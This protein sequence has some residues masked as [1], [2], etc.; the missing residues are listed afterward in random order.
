MLRPA[1]LVLLLTG[2]TP[3]VFAQP[4]SETVPLLREIK[5]WVVGCDNLRNCHALSA[6]SG[7]DEEDYSSLTLHI[8]HQAGPQGYPRLR[9]DHRGQDVD[10]S[11]LTL[12]GQPLGLELTRELHVE[13]D[14]QG[15]DPEVQ[16]YGVIDDAATR[17]WLQRLRNGQ[18]LQLPGE[19]A[20]HVSLSGLSAS[21]LLMDAVQGR[22][23]NVTALARPGKGAPSEVPP[24]APTPILRKFTPAPPLTAQE[25]AGLVAAALQAVTPE[26]GEPE[27]KAGA[28]TARQAMTVTRYDCAAYNCEFNVSSRER[29]APYTETLMDLQPLPLEDA[30]L[31]GSVGYDEAS[32]TLSYFYKQRGIGD[33]GGGASWVFD[34]KRFQLSEFHR[35]PRCTGVGY[36]DWPSLWSTVPAP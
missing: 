5:Q 32:G 27:A 2:A 21:L 19:G 36:G 6:P 11:T 8:W 33:C 3:P 12:D 31:Q 17:R 26:E 20:A 22:V 30:A 15:G 24:Q 7:V 13:L 23:D 18:R 35:M 34:G 28:L 9:F 10:L 25:Q 1:F 29:Q 4:P 16:S 14:D